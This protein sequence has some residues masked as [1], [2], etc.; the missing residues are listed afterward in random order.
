VAESGGH[1]VTRAEL[2]GCLALFAGTSA[3]FLAVTFAYLDRILLLDWPAIALD[4]P[5]ALFAYLTAGIAFQFGIPVL[6]LAGFVFGT[7]VRTL[8]TAKIGLTCAAVALIA[9]ALYVR[10][11]LEMIG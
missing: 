3:V 7:P 1:R 6:S 5:G 9:Y 2:L 11:C 4:S 8:W 10:A